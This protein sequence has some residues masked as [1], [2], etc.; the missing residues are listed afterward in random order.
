MALAKSFLRAAAMLFM[1]GPLVTTSRA[2]PE[3][4]D[5]APVAGGTVTVHCE[6]R[7]TV[8]ASECRVATP[9]EFHTTRWS[10]SKV[11]SNDQIVWSPHFVSRW[12]ARHA[13][14]GC[15]CADPDYFS[16]SVEEE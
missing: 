1:V 10:H 16:G 2:F 13:D 6:C 11:P 14:D 8:N 3:E 5:S 4:P 7:T 15:L 9:A 12:C